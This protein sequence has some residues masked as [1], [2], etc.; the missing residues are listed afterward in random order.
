MD[1]SEFLK[2]IYK[3]YTDMTWPTERL[4]TPP[5]LVVCSDIVL[6]ENREIVF[7]DGWIPHTMG[8]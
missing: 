7:I 4:N 5:S 2:T 1:N 6:A 8:Q 3:F